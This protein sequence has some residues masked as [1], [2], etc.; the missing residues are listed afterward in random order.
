MVTQMPSLSVFIKITYYYNEN[1]NLGKC[2]IY[3]IYPKFLLP[4]LKNRTYEIIS[5]Y[6]CKICVGKM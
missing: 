1:R 3:S 5:P 6:L 4:Q 2:P